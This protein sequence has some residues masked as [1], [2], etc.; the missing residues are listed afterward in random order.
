MIQITAH[1]RLLLA[2]DPADFRKGIDSLAALCQHHFSCDPFN[3]TVFVF[4]NRRRISVK[5]LA[6]DGNGF[7]LCQKRFSSGKLKWWP[8]TQEQA[9]NLRASELLVLLAQGVPTETHIPDN[10][11]EII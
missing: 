4:T 10:W 1:H 11:R 6:Y 7:W 5:L 8:K 3:G 9:L 2:V